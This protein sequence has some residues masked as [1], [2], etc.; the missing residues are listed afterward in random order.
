MEAARSDKYTR[1]LQSS[2]VQDPVS[3]VSPIFKCRRR[4]VFKGSVMNPGARLL[5]I[6]SAQRRT[7][8]ARCAAQSEGGWQKISLI[9]RSAR[10]T[11]ASSAGSC[12]SRSTS[13]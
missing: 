7:G 5:E 12:E 1:Q 11:S 9:A 10:P 8:R 3:G 6:S 2:D 4:S 13:L